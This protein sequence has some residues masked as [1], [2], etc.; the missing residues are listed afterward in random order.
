[1]GIKCDLCLRCFYFN[2]SLGLVAYLNFV[3]GKE[4]QQAAER[5]VLK[6]VPIIADRGLI[7]DNQNKTLVYNQEVFD[8]VF[9]LPTCLL[10]KQNEKKY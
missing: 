10:I 4:Y 3:K 7:F 1:M 6:S 2:F 9:F 8:L 5:N